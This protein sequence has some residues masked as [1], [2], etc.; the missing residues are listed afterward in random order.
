MAALRSLARR[1]AGS[2]AIC[3]AAWLLALQLLAAAGVGF[4]AAP[5]V[6]AA[7]VHPLCVAASDGDGAPPAHPGRGVGCDSCLLCQQRGSALLG[8]AVAPLETSLLVPCAEVADAP[9]C[10][11]AEP[12]ERRA[13]RGGGSSRAPPAFA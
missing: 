10:S 9:S 12:T 2:L 7:A 4:T 13:G 11:P 6:V 8:L 5:G 3:A 1:Y